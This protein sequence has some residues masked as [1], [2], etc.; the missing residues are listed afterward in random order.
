MRRS[1]EI[2]IESESNGTPFW[3]RV[4]EIETGRIVLTTEPLLFASFDNAALGRWL[5]GLAGLP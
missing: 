2:A 1:F 5:K 3:I 4:T